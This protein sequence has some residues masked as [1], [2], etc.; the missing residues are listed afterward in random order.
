MIYNTVNTE[1]VHY[2]ASYFMIIDI[3]SGHVHYNASYFRITDMPS[4]QVHYNVSYFRITEIYHLDRCI[5]MSATSGL[6]RYTIWTG[7]L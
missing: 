1:Q 3:P 6:L 7:A 4:G 2:N 5:I